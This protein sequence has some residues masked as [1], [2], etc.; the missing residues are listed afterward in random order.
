MLRLGGQLGDG[1]R[2]AVLHVDGRQIRVSACGKSDVQAV[3]ALIGTG[4][5]HVE[6]VVHAVKLG[7]QRRGD[8]FRHVTRTGTRP[9]GAYIHHGRRDLRILLH[10]DQLQGDGP[11]HRDHQGDHHRKARSFDKQRQ[12]DGSLIEDL[13]SRT[14]L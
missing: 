8:G 7:F 13:D 6:H 3:R 14:G 12:H 5:F 4:R 10:R 9:A 2:H 1:L 11:E